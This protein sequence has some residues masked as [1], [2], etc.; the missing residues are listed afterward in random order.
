MFFAA[1]DFAVDLVI[2]GKKILS[3]AALLLYKRSYC[4]VIYLIEATMVGSSKQ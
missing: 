3:N 2:S 1:K 4:V